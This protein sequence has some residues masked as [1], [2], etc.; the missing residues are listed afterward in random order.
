M[1][2]ITVDYRDLCRLAHLPAATSLA[3]LDRRLSLAKGEL[4]R[5]AADGRALQDAAGVWLAVDSPTDLRI[6]LADTNRPDLWCV[7]GIARQLRD[8]A[9]RERRAYAFPTEAHQ[10]LIIQV[11][12]ALEAIRPYI[13][14]FLACGHTLTETELVAFIEGQ[15]ALTRNYGRKRKTVSIGLYQ[16]EGLTFPVHYRA[17]ALDAVR[18]VPLAPA[19]QTEPP[20]PVDRSLT[21]REIMQL[22]PT[23]QEYGWILDGFATVP[24]LSDDQGEVL[25]LPPIINSNTLGRVPA[26]ATALFVEATGEEQTQVLLTLNILAANLAD[27][28]WEIAPVTTHYPY[29][30]PR[31][32]AVTTPQPLAYSL[33]VPVAEFSRILGEAVVPHDIRPTLAAY[34][35]GAR[36]EGADIVATPPDYRQ[37]YLH[38]VDV[39][40]DYAISRGYDVIE[41][42]MPPDFTVGKLDPAT[43]LEDHL[44]DL[45]IGFGFEELVCNIL[46]S[47]AT[48]RG[49]M[50][51]DEQT[52]PTSPA[53]HGGRSV[54]IE[55]P[56]NRSY[57]QL[58]DWV[59]P[60]LL[61]VE[62]HSTGALYP[63]RIFEAGEVA[64]YDP[65]HELGARTESRL[66]ALIADEQATFDSAQ[67]VLYA[68]F[69]QL[70][71]DFVVKPWTHPSFIAGRAALAV[72]TR[73]PD[74]ATASYPV[75][76][77]GE[78]SPRVL[79]NWNARTPAAAFELSIDAL[80]TLLTQGGNLS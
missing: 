5:R 53:F 50:D 64:V 7:E 2:T 19:V 1:P 13:G 34:G 9:L 40:E 76:F 43:E 68:L 62:S 11:D 48:V 31:G 55:N 49:Q 79:T 80:L 65:V 70:G 22:H 47:A 4:S 69:A 46:T 56:M 28:G 12:P 67:S 42:L 54:C 35:V 38:P 73:T 32:Q 63:H 78:L 27:R 41:P 36:V 8:H 71:L 59:L 15:E 16:G 52:A 51:V 75:G 57:V 44:R 45:M 26:G 3:E 14:G 21:P 74:G 77:I 66:A 29:A 25:S 30:T 37:D 20:W 58:R 72:V 23:G 24:F 61:E 17:V 10:P 6:E 18:F 60:S 39:I 33:R